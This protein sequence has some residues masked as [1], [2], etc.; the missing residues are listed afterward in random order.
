V[1][2]FIKLFAHIRQICTGDEIV[3][4]KMIITLVAALAVTAI[5]SAAAL[6]A[7][8][9]DT[10]STTDMSAADMSDLAAMAMPKAVF[11]TIQAGNMAGGDMTFTVPYGAKVIPMDNKEIAAVAT[12]NMPLKGTCNMTSGSGTISMADALPAKATIDYL[13]RSTIP[14][15]GTNAVLALQD[16]KMTGAARGKGT[17]NLQFGKVTVYLPDGTAK[18]MKPDRPVRMSVNMDRMMMSIEA[19]P[20][21]AKMMAG[22]LKPGATF[23]AGA[24]PVRL[25]DILAV[26]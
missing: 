20:S 26:K 8:S 4:I 15:A 13:N 7:A 14:V 18:T 2:L 16:F 6:P 1:K 24:T 22:M 12:Y 3:N 5:L 10:T 11:M 9:Q 19:N 25:N 17:Y 21:L 23:P